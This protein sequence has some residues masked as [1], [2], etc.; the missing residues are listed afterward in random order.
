[1]P[2]REKMQVSLEDLVGAY[3][4][5]NPRSRKMFEQAQRS[6]PGGNSRTGVYLDPFPL[7]AKSGE[8]VHLI[9]LDGHRLLD[10]VNNNSALI[11]GHTHP[12][13]V[14]A[15]QEQAAKGTGFS[16]PTALEVE[17]AE[18]LQERMPS[19]ERIRFCNSGTEAVLNALRA[20][21]A[22][23]GRRKI[24]KF[25]GAYH[26]TADPALVS[27]LPPLGPDLGPAHRP[28]S[29]LSSPGL[30]PTLL[31]EVVTLPF[32]DGEACAQI[33]DHH[34]SD[35]AAVLVDPLATG[36][37]MTLPTDGFL[38]QLRKITED[39]GVILIFDEI[40][41]FRAT[42]GGAQELY[43]VRPDLTCLAKVIAGGTPGGAFGGRAEIMALYDPSSGNPM[44]PHAGTYNAN[45]LS[46]VAGLATLK[47]LT[48]EA[49]ARLDSLAQHLRTQLKTVFRQAGIQAQITLVGS[50]FRIHFLPSRPRNY[51]E[52]AQ[53][54]K[55]LQRWLFFWLINEGILWS[56]GGNLSLP[57]DE[58]HVHQLVSSVRT[59]FQQ[60]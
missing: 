59:A 24:A 48:P 29:V 8:G 36:A 55:L 12:E 43:G 32:N 16:L 44:I 41:S 47:L 40:I 28:R 27:H 51:R 19:L 14:T 31:E 37:G 56:Q 10:F 13:V 21:K 20:A 1:M 60:L 50:L 17:L 22:F 11:L 53:D 58:T 18:L 9:D 52:A 6:L 15:L 38:S 5:Q 7:Y 25:E 54:D 49:Y 34:T 2:V 33:I 45:P 4:T 26:G 42:R 46:M 3:V 30:S 23:T 57:M 39:A 35:L